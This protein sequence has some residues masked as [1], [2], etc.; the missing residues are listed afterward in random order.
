MPGF[1][2]LVDTATKPKLPTVQK[3]DLRHEPAASAVVAGL[4]ASRKAVVAI[5]VRGG[6]QNL[7]ESVEDNMKAM[8]LNGYERIGLILGNTFSDQ[9]KPAIDVISNG[10]TY[11]IIEDAKADAYTKQALFKLVRDAYQ[12]DVLPLIKKQKD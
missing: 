11:A 7:I 3:H 2:Q 4:S 1:S 5:L 9:N 12:E 6:D 8:I 10:H